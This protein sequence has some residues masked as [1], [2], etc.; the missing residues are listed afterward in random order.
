M[1]NHWIII[2]LLINTSGLIFGEQET[3]DRSV[4]S[5]VD[6]PGSYLCALKINE[7]VRRRNVA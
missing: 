1:N 5:A 6:L 3:Q 7:K 2:Y 4:A